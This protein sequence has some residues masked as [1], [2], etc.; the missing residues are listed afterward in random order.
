MP[1]VT[2]TYG[3]TTDLPLNSFT[4][5]E[6]I[7]KDWSTTPSGSGT[8]FTNGELV[9]L[10]G[11]VTLYAQW[12]ASAALI[13][14]TFNANASGATGTMAPE[15]EPYGVATA[16]T[17]NAYV[18]PGFTFDDWSPSPTG[19]G[20]SYTNDGTYAFTSSTVTLYAI[21]TVNAPVSFAGGTTP[22][23]SGYVLPSPSNSDV[24]T[25][26]S[27]EWTVPTLNC[28]DTPNNRSATWVGTGGFGWESGGNSGV[29]LQTG[30]EDDCVNGAQE[31]SGWF[32]IYPSTPNTQ[33]T[34]KDFP[35]NP[36]DVIRG[37][38]EINTDD[39]WTTV[40]ENLTTGLQGVFSVGYEWN[41]ATIANN[42]LV[43]PIQGTATGTSY[44][45][46][47]SAEWIVEDT[48]VAYTS[49]Y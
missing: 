26:M 40:L 36:G 13:T 23:W 7:F 42:T 15:I 22:T 3:S 27:G 29:L 31:D 39:E 19:S 47:D 8:T 48:G 38:V 10:T 35:V 9:K 1:S 20:A 46:G 32:E 30:T 37:V 41:V 5:D 12:T 21:W 45:G 16:L 14:V 18:N 11:S 33:E 2:G 49:S 17:D 44:V 34:F 6:E 4:N 25:Y 43:G 28:A 24:F